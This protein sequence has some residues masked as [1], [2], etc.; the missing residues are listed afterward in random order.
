MIEGISSNSCHLQ[1]PRPTIT[2]RYRLT[3]LLRYCLP[4]AYASI[5]WVGI[6]AP[7]CKSP[8]HMVTA[9]SSGCCSIKAQVSMSRVPGSA[10]HYR[11][12]QLEAM[13][14]FCRCWLTQAQTSGHYKDVKPLGAYADVYSATSKH[15][16]CIVLS[17]RCLIPH[18]TRFYLA[19]LWT[20]QKDMTRGL[21]GGVKAVDTSENSHGDDHYAIY[22]TRQ[23]NS[24]FSPT[25]E[26]KTRSSIA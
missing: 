14:K 4:K 2:G 5:R 19:E 26:I 1:I 15:A 9:R 20:R 3:K 8:Q 6:P 7:L 22:T 16:Q 11:Q 12:L 21:Q 18:R 24:L 17:E 23:S 13:L 10:R 25:I